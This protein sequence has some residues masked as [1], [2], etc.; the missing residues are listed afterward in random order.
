VPASDYCDYR[1]GKGCGKS[2]EFAE[3]G[4]ELVNLWVH[5][6]KFLELLPRCTL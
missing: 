1:A 4:G 6:M 2:P 5:A 3:P